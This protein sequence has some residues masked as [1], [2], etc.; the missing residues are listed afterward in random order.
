MKIVLFGCGKIYNANKNKIPIDYE[1]VAILDNSKELIG[2]TVDDHRII[3]IKDL[4]SYAFDYIILMSDYACAMRE[5]LLENGFSEDIIIHYKDFFGGES[6][7]QRVISSKKDGSLNKKVLIISN[8]LGY[9]GA[10]IVLVR[11]ARIVTKL[12]FDVSVA[13]SN[14]DER[15]IED[16]ILEKVDVIIQDNIENASVENLMWVLD[17]DKVLVNTYKMIICAVRIAR[18]RDVDVWLH[19]VKSAYAGYEYWEK[20]IQDGLRSKNIRLYA[21]TKYAE[22]SFRMLYN[23]DMKIDILPVPIDDWKNIEHQTVREDVTFLNVGGF[24][25]TKAQDILIQAIDGMNNNNLKVLFVGKA[26]ETA[27]GQTILE[28]IGRSDICT[29]LGEKRND[30]LVKIYGLSDVVIVSSR[31][32][33]FSIVAAEAMMMGKVC[34]V[35]DQ[36]GIADYIING[37]NGFVF[38]AD[39]SEE[40]SAVMDW[41]VVNRNRLSEIGDNAR[42]T[43]EQFFST[44]CVSLAYGKLLGVKCCYEQGQI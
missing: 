43:Y 9:H 20:D 33:T 42:N 39:N 37:K 31:E 15:L 29:Y 17:Y 30:E 16:L 6:L 7:S 25:P 34:I 36:C 21:V 13:T 1:I 40:L 38:H 24:N 2:K 23:Y 19:E 28:Y 44:K 18:F 10:A 3:A 4:N 41:C 11:F 27:Y 5:Q 8:P 35:S 32:E 26:Y 12:G 14:A 22:D